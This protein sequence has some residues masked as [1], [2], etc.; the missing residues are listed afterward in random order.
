MEGRGGLGPVKIVFL[1]SSVELVPR[2]LWSHPQ[3]LRSARRYGIE[4]E[5]LLLDKSLHYNAMAGLP[6]KWKRGRPDIL[7]VALLTSTETPLYQEGLLRIYF[8]VYDGRVFEV[9]SGVRIPKNYERFKGLI[10]QLL[11]T[12][13]VPP[14]VESLLYAC[15][16]RALGSS[17]R[18]RG[19]LYSCGR[20]AHPPLPFSSQP[21]LYPQASL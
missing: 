17:S 11:K 5:D 8:Q 6:A 10:A 16:R 20:E 14:K 12:E 4:P 19:G 18:R 7:H 13:R 15:T 21:G 1:E 2:S 9:R 3:V